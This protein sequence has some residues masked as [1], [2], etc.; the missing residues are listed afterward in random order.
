M[1]RLRYAEVKDIDRLCAWW[2]DGSVMA[3]AGFPNGIQT[4]KDKLKESILNDKMQKRMIIEYGHPI[5]EM[6][7]YLRG[8]KAEIG[9]KICDAPYQ[10]KGLGSQAIRIL[11]DHLFETYDLEA[12]ILDT[13]LNNTRAQHVYEKIGFKKVGVNID[14]WTDQLGHLQSSVDYELTKEVYCEGI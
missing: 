2:A 12:I 4:D 1:L 3:H 6:A 9:I 8:S 7:Y 10:N 11:I 5:G 13:N 14:S